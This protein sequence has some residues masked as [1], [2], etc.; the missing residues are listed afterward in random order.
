M[1]GKERILCVLAGGIPDRVPVT[2]FVQQ[3]YLSYY[4]KRNDTDRVIDASRLAAELGFDLMTRQTNHQEPHYTRKSFPNWEVEK[5]EEIKAGNIHRHLKITT[6]GGVLSQT[7]SAPYNPATVAGIHFISTKFMI[8][9]ER[10]FELFRKY[11]PGVD[12][13]YVQNMKEAA[14]QA[15]KITGDLGI[16]CPWG[17]GGVFNA[18]TI[19]RDVSQLCMDP[20]EDEDFYNEFMAFLTSL[21]EK[22]YELLADTE[23]ECIGIQG[24][25]A[26]GKLVGPDFFRKYI[27][28]YEK[29]LVDVTKSRGKYTLYH[30]CGPAKV[31]YENYRELGMTVWE[32]ISPPPQ[33]DNDIAEVKKL[34]GKDLVLSGNLDQIYFLK[35]A[36]AG[37]VRSATEKLIAVCKPGGKYLFDTSDYLEPDTP[38]E[39][40]KAMI[41]TAISCG[42]Y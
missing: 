24:N 38:L 18:A 42:K 28:P 30:N 13:E 27:Q 40:I 3:E 7:E 22:D 37:E 21:L 39:N 12:N 11:M 14:A 5:H 31:L 41:E 23:H 4:Y 26:N 34:L 9:N 17:T 35:K 20:Y 32:T 36:D 6:P 15:H 25:M 2:I 29:R 8:N 10:D 33:G 1:T 19:L 16:C